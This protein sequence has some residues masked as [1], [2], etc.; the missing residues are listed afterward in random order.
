M[1]FQGKHFNMTYLYTMIVECICCMGMITNPTLLFVVIRCP[2]NVPLIVKLYFGLISVQ[3]FIMVTCYLFLAPRMLVHNG[4]FVFLTTGRGSEWSV[5]P[6]LIL[7]YNATLISTLVYSTNSFIYR[8]IQLCRPHLFFIYTSFKCLAV[9]TVI[10]VALITNWVLMV[11]FTGWPKP[12]F[13][14]HVKQLLMTDY[15]FNLGNRA[16]VGFSLD[17]LPKDEFVM[18]M[19]ALSL[20]LVLVCIAFSCALRVYFYLKSNALSSQT[21]RM[22]KTLFVVLLIQTAC[23]VI[24]LH[25]PL[26][27]IYLLLFTGCNTPWP[28]NFCNGILMSAYPFFSPIIIMLYMKDYRRF[29]FRMGG[30]DRRRPSGTTMFITTAGRPFAS[31]K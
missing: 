30:Y 15:D 19:E 10:N 14:A 27:T 1:N 12:P 17:M 29:I 22:Q 13:T 18:L 4:T 16:F 23:P 7:I 20:P 8:F 24:L 11:Y 9:Y 5:A 21:K 25:L 31:L 26:F 6:T 2:L 28:L 3:N